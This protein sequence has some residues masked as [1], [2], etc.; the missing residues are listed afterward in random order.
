MALLDQPADEARFGLEVE[1]VIFVHQWRH[2]EEGSLHHLVRHW[3]ILDELHQLVLEDDA[4]WRGG[5]VLA[6][7]EVGGGAADREFRVRGGVGKQIG[8]AGE[9]ADRPGVDRAADR[10][11]IGEGE[12]GGAER[13]EIGAGV[14]F[15]AGA[16]GLVNP[17]GL[18]DEIGGLLR[19]EQIGLLEVIED[20]VLAPGGIAEAPVAALGGD[21]RVD[22]LAG[23]AAGAGAPE[24]HPFGGG[25]LARLEDGHGVGPELD[26]EIGHGAGGGQRVIGHAGGWMGGAGAEGGD[27]VLDDA[28]PGGGQFG[29]L[30]G[31]F[32]QAPDAGVGHA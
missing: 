20:R 23:E 2:V 29:R 12:I 14:E 26:R 7:L 13:V 18:G 10:L 9:Q 8:E 11:G 6:E 17:F 28:G 3:R 27:A 24:L 15:G 25:L 4:A 19:G 1:E 31:G 30:R 22:R 5:D 16:G 32:R 21:D